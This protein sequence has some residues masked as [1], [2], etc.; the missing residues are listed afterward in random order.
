MGTEE[1]AGVGWAGRHP[2]SEKSASQPRT[3]F[4]IPDEATNAPLYSG[5]SDEGSDEDLIEDN[6]FDEDSADDD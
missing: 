2:D 4:P 5:S 6:S 1:K 3:P